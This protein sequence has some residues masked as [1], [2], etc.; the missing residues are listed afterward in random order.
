MAD[1]IPRYQGQEFLESIRVIR[2]RPTDFGLSALSDLAGTFGAQAREQEN[3]ALSLEFSQAKTTARQRA[4]EFAAASPYDA[5]QFD[6]QFGAYMETAVEGLPEKL[7]DAAKAEFQRIG[8]DRYNGILGKAAERADKLHSAA[9]QHA[10]NDDKSDYLSGAA[11]GKGADP[12]TIQARDAFVAQT[13]A[14]VAAGYIPAEQAK[15]LID[16]ADA[17]AR[18]LTYL[19]FNRGTYQKYGYLTAMKELQDDLGKDESIPVAMREKLLDQGQ[20][21][22]R[23]QQGLTDYAEA[24]AKKKLIELQDATAKTGFERLASGELTPD[25]VRQNKEDLSLAEFKALLQSTRGDAAHAD[26]PATINDLERRINQG[27][28]VAEDIALAHRRGSLKNDRMSALMSRNRDIQRGRGPATDYDRAK[29]YL[30][31]MLRPGPAVQD[32]N[33]FARQAQA[34]R[35]FDDYVR[36][37]PED[38][39]RTGPEIWKYAEE[40]V[41]RFAL[42]DWKEVSATMPLPRFFVGKRGEPNIE[43]TEAAIIRAVKEGRMTREEAAKEAQIIDQWRDAIAR[44]KAQEG[45]K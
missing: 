36:G 6:A 13:N 31:D 10:S 32:V 35:M 16:E 25:W 20:E 9:L 7:R 15:S 38:K 30:K 42:I 28:D 27:E 23:E 22:V 18:G 19:A 44:R 5:K 24:E 37:A 14:R 17:E 12:M 4:A 34:E 41:G 3:Q 33:A 40:T 8:V 11:A 29:D 1:M 39:P 21:W 2:A 45:V 26:D 43:A